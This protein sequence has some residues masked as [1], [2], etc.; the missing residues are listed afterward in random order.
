MTEP[1]QW[2]VELAEDSCWASEANIRAYALQIQ[3]VFEQQTLELRNE[4]ERKERLW[5]GPTNEEAEVFQ[6]A[7]ERGWT[8]P[9][10]PPDWIDMLD[11]A[12]AFLKQED[13]EG[14]VRAALD[15]ARDTPPELRVKVLSTI[16][17]ANGGQP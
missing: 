14:N 17:R 3:R 4:Y 2:A 9:K 15:A 11:D 1:E 16:L 8:L 5:K 12:F 10:D 13:Q 6:R 7:S